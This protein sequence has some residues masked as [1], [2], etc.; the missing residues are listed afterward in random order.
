MDPGQP[1][2]AAPVREPVA[3]EPAPLP[4]GWQEFL[5]RRRAARAGELA[6]LAPKGPGIRPHE[7]SLATYL[8]MRHVKGRTTNP[9]LVRDLRIANAT[10]EDTRAALLHGRG[11]VSD[12]L[13]RSG[14]HSYIAVS[15][16]RHIEQRVTGGLEAQGRPLDATSRQALSAAAAACFGAGMCSEYADL[17]THL[18]APRLKPWQRIER[19]YHRQLDHAFAIVRTLGRAPRRDL[20]ID[21]WAYGPAVL[22]E[23]AEFAVRGDRQVGRLYGYDRPGARRRYVAFAQWMNELNHSSAVKRAA[24][25]EEARLRAHGATLDPGR[26]WEPTSVYKGSF[27]ARVERLADEATPLRLALAAVHT[28]RSMGAGVREAARDYGDWMHAHPGDFL[29]PRAWRVR[30]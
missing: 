10:V 21:P 17:A 13:R 28:A 8:A 19:T 20:V 30:P 9:G 7:A 12:D 18:H 24:R 3:S 22:R 2:A 4:V 29:R 11:N 16:A 15:L 27:E 25:G 1:L 26:L 23:D 5:A 6:A 14:N